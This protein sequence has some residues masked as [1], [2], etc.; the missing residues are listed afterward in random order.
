MTD[1]SPLDRSVSTLEERLTT[2]AERTL[3]RAAANGLAQINR[4]VQQNVRANKS[5]LEDFGRSLR[6]SVSG[7]LENFASGALRQL[8]AQPLQQALS[9]GLSSLFGGYR[10]NGGAVMPGRAFVVGEKGAELFVPGQSGTIVPN[11][12]GAGGGAQTVNV[13]IN[14]PD[15]ASF[16]TSR[17]QVQAALASAVRQGS[18]NL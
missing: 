9:G 2:L 7:A 16:L 6:S 14:T 12:G 13:T 5:A 8:T 3:P 17:A 15:A 4:D 10:A 11:G 1:N 18:R